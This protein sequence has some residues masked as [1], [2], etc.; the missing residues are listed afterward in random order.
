MTLERAIKFGK[1]AGCRGC[2]RIAEGVPHSDE[3]HSR[4]GRLV[5]E[6][7]VAKSESKAPI[8]PASQVLPAKSKEN[9]CQANQGSEQFQNDFW[10]FDA[11]QNAWV[12]VHH[13]FGCPFI[14]IYLML[15][16]EGC[17]SYPAFR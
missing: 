1:T 17:C 14:W 3:C 12:R 11:D 5:E 16:T 10:K 13:S 6:E 2:E 9:M 7:R 8:T 15:G 4:F